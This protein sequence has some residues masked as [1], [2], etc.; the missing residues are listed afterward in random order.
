MHDPESTTRPAPP[1]LGLDDFMRAFAPTARSNRSVKALYKL[2]GSLA[3]D[4]TLDGPL[5]ARVEAV[6]RLAKWV[7]DRARVPA[8]EDAP[9]EPLPQ[10]GR[11][12]L[13]L[14]VL[15][16]VPGY[17]ALV[18]QLVGSVLAETSGLQLFA[19][20][21][22]P[23]DRGLVGETVDRLSRRLLPAPHD[24]RDLGQL[25]EFMFPKRRD[26]EW[27]HALEPATI[28]ALVAVLQ[29][30]DPTILRP[31]RASVA[32]AIALLAI[33]TSALGFSDDLRKR[34]APAPLADSPFY[35]L[36]RHAQ[37]LA[38]SLD[39][40]RE[41]VL[42]G[43]ATACRAT[44]EE[45]RGALDGVLLALEDQGVSVDVV[46]RVE[47]IVKSLDR[48]ER[49]LATL[50]Q[51]GGAPAHDAASKLLARLVEDKLRD[52]NLVEIARTNLRLLAR[53]II[54]RAGT[55]GEHYITVSRAEY[56]NMLISAG[57]G[58]LL[59][60]GTAA[61]KFLIGWAKFAPFVEGALAATNYSG[62]FIVMQLLGMT[63]ATK[64]P[65]MTA[66]ALAGALRKADERRDLAE[67]STTIARITRSQLAAAIGNIGM[68]IPA[69][70]G[71]DFAWQRLYGRHFLDEATAHYVLHS[72]HP[73][74]SG[75][76]FYAALTGVLLWTASVGAGW[77]EN[78]A[79]YRRLPEAI[80]EHR[81]RRLIGRGIPAWFSRFFARNISGF[82]GNTT[83]GVLLGM[84]PVLGKFFGLPL[85]VRHVTLSTGALTLG[86]CALGSHSL[87]E[88][89]FAYAALGIGIIG[90]LNFGVSFALAIA[91]ALRAREVQTNVLRIALAT[92]K[93]FFRTPLAFFYPP[94][95]EGAAAA[96]RHH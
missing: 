71:L 52:R 10:P 63:L 47:L 14:Q 22:L 84:T 57:G 21:G 62:S 2:L 49:L 7:R 20:R 28:E 94:A 66:A 50:A 87:T 65:S 54:E 37:D 60:A 40:T 93:Q 92:T 89:A 90:V 3:I 43:H 88:P 12:R 35:R 64:Q 5:D 44:A 58:G 42:A 1:A 67:M 75:T 36:P 51:E 95:S 85:D 30:H 17:G 34:S 39:D 33:R 8:P 16:E 80:A 48:M 46:Y 61:L 9:R 27:L 96:A 77:L 18:A 23:S 76:V 13:L 69:C 15:H 73:F 19:C 91:V 79:V 86:C 74:E 25:V 72:L 31:L 6:E 55:T 24:E 41:G 26:A 45:C 82:G 38:R 83:L 59:T 53:K 81:I 11:L 70:F 4:G 56:R 29:A 32:E 78:W 68:V